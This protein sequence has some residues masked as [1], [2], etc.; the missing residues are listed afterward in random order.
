VRISLALAPVTLALSCLAGCGRQEPSPNPQVD[1]A[2]HPDPVATLSTDASQGMPP[3]SATTA[4]ATTAP[5]TTA[6]ATTAPAT[7]ATPAPPPP[8]PAAS[9]LRSAVAIEPTQRTP[10]ATGAEGVVDPRSAFE[11]QLSTR[12]EDARLLVLD[13]R[14][15]VVPATSSRELSAGTRLTVAPSVPLVPG[16]R[17]ALR[18]DGAGGREL[19]DASGR[20]YAPLV[21]TILVS[22]TPP[23]PAPKR[24]APK[25]RRRR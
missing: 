23:P 2:A 25:K 12:A 16:S 3:A 22:G 14:Q 19:H 11:V 5:A 21:L 8:A 10:L 4:S 15:D 7:T 18:I 6:P 20:A 24:P 17:Y 1:A 9:L 13:A